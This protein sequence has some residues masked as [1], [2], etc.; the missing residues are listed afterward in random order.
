MVFGL[1]GH[2]VAAETIRNEY[3]SLKK[4]V[5]LAYTPSLVTSQRNDRSDQMQTT[6][7]TMGSQ[8]LDSV[9]QKQ[10]EEPSISN[11]LPI[12]VDVN[13]KIVPANVSK[14]KN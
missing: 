9:V 2:K 13:V 8:H 11:K 3:T 10:S 6:E 7:E 12:K 1:S 14:T 4:N 5:R